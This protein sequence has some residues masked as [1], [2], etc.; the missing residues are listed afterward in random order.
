MKCTTRTLR[1]I[2][3]EHVTNASDFS[4]CLCSWKKKSCGKHSKASKT[5]LDN[6]T[7][8]NPHL[9]FNWRPEV[10]FYRSVSEN[11]MFASNIL[12]YP[13]SENNYLLSIPLSVLL[14]KLLLQQMK[15]FRSTFIIKMRQCILRHFVH[16]MR[17]QERNC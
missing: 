8:I 1:Q 13:S 7:L 6:L 3:Y 5:T 15:I 2:S 9:S 4:L 10:S 14:A 17:Q 16:F 11:A 12:E